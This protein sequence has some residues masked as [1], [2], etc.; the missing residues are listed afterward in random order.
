MQLQRILQG[1]SWSLHDPHIELMYRSPVDLYLDE[2]L[3]D[4]LEVVQRTGAQRLAIDSLGDMRAACVDEL[5]F[6]EC[7]YSLLQTLRPRQ[8]Q[9]DRGP[10][11]FQTCS[12]SP[13]CPNT[14]SHTCPTTS[15]CSN[16]SAATPN[17]NAPSPC[18]RPAAAPTNSNYV[19]TPSP[20]TV[21]PLG[22]FIRTKPKLGLALPIDGQ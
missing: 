19:N 13:G 14:G 17:S 11:R 2:W 15:S 10:R 3:Y 20:Q 5:R 8:R 9:C 21:S 18:S 1:F 16:S 4:L 6:R 22:D 7:V 12:E